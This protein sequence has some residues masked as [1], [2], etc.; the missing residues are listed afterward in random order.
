ML[1]WADGFGHYG[2][3]P[4]LK[5]SGFYS[6]T[7][8]SSYR[9][10]FFSLSAAKP[11]TGP[12]AINIASGAPS[13]N[14]REF[15][16]ARTTVGFGCAITADAFPAGNN[17]ILALV[18]STLGNV[19]NSK[20]AAFQ[21]NTDGSITINIGGTIV[22]HTAT[23]L[24][25]PGVYFYVEALLFCDHVAGTLELRVNENTVFTFAGNTMGMSAPQITGLY[26]GSPNT[27]CA[28]NTM[29]ADLV[30]WDTTTAFNNDFLGDVRCRT[31]LPDANGALQNW[32]VTGAASAFQAIN[33]VPRNAATHYIASS[34][35]NDI[36]SFSV[37]DVPVT[38]SS[39]AALVAI[40]AFGKTDAGACS[41]QC[42]LDSGGS[43]ALGSVI[44]PGIGDALFPDFFPIDPATGNPW[45]RAAVN[46]VLTRNQRTV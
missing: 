42:S 41:V 28:A 5:A 39:V 22:G 27:N 26:F 34:A 44:S 19:T 35:V 10:D 13:G 21:F 17:L 7:Y 4:T 25:A 3:D 18:N 36:S 37:A 43:I 6:G 33:Q 46:A 8:G 9:N 40:N 32:A 31:L 38:T 45:T 24:F 1:I 2:D 30:I 12:D 16:G 15:G 14:W 29:Q 11:R 23:N 20:Q